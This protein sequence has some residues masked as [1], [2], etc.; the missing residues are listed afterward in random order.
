MNEDGIGEYAW[1]NNIGKRGER[2]ERQKSTT[3][4]QYPFWVAPNNISEKKM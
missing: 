1:K 4:S 2:E 3:L